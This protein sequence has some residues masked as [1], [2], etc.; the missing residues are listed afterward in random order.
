M[1]SYDWKLFLNAEYKGMK[2]KIIPEAERGETKN[3]KEESL[4]QP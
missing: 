1:N 3:V 4:E 2:K